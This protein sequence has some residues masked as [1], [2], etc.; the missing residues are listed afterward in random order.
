MGTSGR[1]GNKNNPN[2]ISGEEVIGESL[3]QSNIDCLEDIGPPVPQ[4]LEALFQRHVGPAFFLGGEGG[5]GNQSLLVKSTSQVGGIQDSVS[6][7][8]N[9][10]QLFSLTP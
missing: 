3:L 2:S 4:H 1:Q 6:Q 10:G 8:K 9:H 5:C 7:D